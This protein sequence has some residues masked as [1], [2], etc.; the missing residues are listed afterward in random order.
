MDA[1]AVRELQAP[2]K[3]RYHDDPD[4]AVSLRADDELD[5]SGVACRVRT[6]ALAAAGLHPGDRR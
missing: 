6:A 5:G 2:L 4:S 1:I 3:S